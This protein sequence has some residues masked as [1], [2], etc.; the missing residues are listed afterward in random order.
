[1]SLNRFILISHPIYVTAFPLRDS[2]S[3]LLAFVTLLLPQEYVPANKF[4]K[5]STPNGATCRMRTLKGHQFNRRISISN[6]FSLK[7]T[8]LLCIAASAISK[9][10]ALLTSLSA[11]HA[12]NHITSGLPMS[13]PKGCNSIKY[14]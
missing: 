2:S 11:S 5:M 3:F 12:I 7:H 8:S 14:K 4:K 1:M 9:G 6:W 10:R 13:S